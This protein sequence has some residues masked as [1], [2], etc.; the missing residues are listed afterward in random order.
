VL[1]RANTFLN[2]SLLMAF[3]TAYP[4]FQVLLLFIIPVRIVWVAVFS[5]AIMVLGSVGQ[6]PVVAATLGAAFLNYMIFFRRD[7]PGIFGRAMPRAARPATKPSRGEAT[8]HRCET[9]GKTEATHPDLEF[10]VSSD[11]HEYCRE[12]LPPR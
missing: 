12:H 9:C 11:G 2:L 3:A 6:P 5:A 8:L 4:G 1:G 10:R 7:L